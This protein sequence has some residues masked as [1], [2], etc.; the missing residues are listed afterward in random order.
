[1]YVCKGAGEHKKGYNMGLSGAQS[2]ESTAWNYSQKSMDQEWE[3]W[4]PVQSLLTS[5]VTELVTK[6]LSLLLPDKVDWQDALVYS[7]FQTGHSIIFNALFWGGRK[8]V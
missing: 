2:L 3:N 5:C 1:M 6:S 7:T 4:F 8:K